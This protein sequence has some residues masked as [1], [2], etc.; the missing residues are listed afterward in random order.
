[1]DET[2][3]YFDMPGNTTVDVKATKTVAEWTVVLACMADGTKLTPMVIFKCKS[4]TKEKFPS[5]VIA[6]V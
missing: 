2:P 6:T 5:E 4:M 1:M 3:M